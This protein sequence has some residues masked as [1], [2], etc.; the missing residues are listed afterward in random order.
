MC[1]KLGWDAAE[2]V[3]DQAGVGIDRLA[4]TQASELITELTNRKRSAAAG[5]R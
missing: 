4:F 3:R 5:A 1:S 2:F